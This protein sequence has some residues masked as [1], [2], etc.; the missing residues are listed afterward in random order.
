MKKQSWPQ[1]LQSNVDCS[2]CLVLL[3]VFVF[4]LAGGIEALSSY[5]YAQ[6]A[7]TQSY[8]LT[9]ERDDFPAA[10]PVA[11][12]PTV[13]QTAVATRS[14]FAIVYRN[15]L[16]QRPCGIPTGPC[17]YTPSGNVTATFPANIIQAG[18][19]VTVFFYR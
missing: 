6:P 18:D 16:L 17:D 3:V 8:G 19:L 7:V 2:F 15:G 12:S 11:N 9:L 10:A 1:F 13:F 5:V 4:I 14:S